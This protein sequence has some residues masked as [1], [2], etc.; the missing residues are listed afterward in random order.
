MIQKFAI[1]LKYLSLALFFLFFIGINDKNI[2]DFM[3]FRI[4]LFVYLIFSYI[5]FIFLTEKRIKK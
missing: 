5:F 3:W 2:L 1:F 4:V